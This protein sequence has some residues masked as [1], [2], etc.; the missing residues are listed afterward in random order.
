MLDYLTAGIRAV[1]LKDISACLC[2]KGV[3]K[4]LLCIAVVILA[5]VLDG[6]LPQEI[7]LRDLTILFFIATEGMSILKNAE[8]LIPLPEKLQ[9]VLKVLKE[10]SNSPSKSEE[11]KSKREE[12]EENINQ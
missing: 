3:A 10:K 9:S 6:L 8:G 2:L 1:Y 11:S 5:T 4:K 7:P 12:N